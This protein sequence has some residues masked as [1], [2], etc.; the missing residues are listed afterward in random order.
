MTYLIASVLLRLSL[1]WFRLLPCSSHSRTLVSFTSTNQAFP[2]K[3]YRQ[4]TTIIVGAALWAADI[5]NK[6]TEMT[7]GTAPGLREAAKKAE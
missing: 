6:E 5:E 7:D 4:L 3:N 2:D 1:R